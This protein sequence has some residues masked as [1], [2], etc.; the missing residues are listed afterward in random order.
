MAHSRKFLGS[1]SSSST[2]LSRAASSGSRPAR[3]ACTMEHCTAKS[4]RHRH[5]AQHGLHVHLLL[6]WILLVSVAGNAVCSRTASQV[7]SIANCGVAW[8]SVRLWA[9]GFCA[10]R[11]E[12]A[13][14]SARCTALAYCLPARC[15]GP[16]C[17][18]H[19]AHFIRQQYNR[20]QARIYEIAG[21]H[22]L[23]KFPGVLRAGLDGSIRAAVTDLLTLPEIAAKRY[24][25]QSAQN[26]QAVLNV[27]TAY[28]AECISL[29]NKHK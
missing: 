13:L 8:E 16:I 24:Y 5:P 14:M 19:G 9:S 20:F 18:I 29:H 17:C 23:S 6:A 4:R 2:C 3:L 21:S 12:V 15:T 10:Q 25:K 28:A 11:R 27:P 26:L 1:R 7:A 22:C